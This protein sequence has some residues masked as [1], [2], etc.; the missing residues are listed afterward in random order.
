MRFC[1][2]IYLSNHFSIYPLKSPPIGLFM[3]V[4]P[5]SDSRNTQFFLINR[6]L[7]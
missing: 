5:K 3:T 7:H 6:Y 4:H 1:I 2:V